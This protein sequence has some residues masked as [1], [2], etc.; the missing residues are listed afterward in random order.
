MKPVFISYRRSDAG[1]L[2]D[3]VASAVRG[4]FGQDSVFIDTGDIKKGTRWAEVIET[5]LRGMSALICV[6]GGDWVGSAERT[7][8]LA[9]IGSSTISPTASS[10]TLSS[11]AI[12]FLPTPRPA[13]VRIAVTTSP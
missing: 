9:S 10:A 1:E 12:V 3:Q 11:R 8:C 7:R 5:R 6:M 4:V 2:A 13:T